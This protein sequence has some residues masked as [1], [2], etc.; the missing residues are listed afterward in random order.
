MGAES[1]RVTCLEKPEIRLLIPH[2][3]SMCLLDRVLYWDNDSILCSSETHRDRANPLRR[4][5]QLCAVHAF[6]YGAQSVALHGGLRARRAGQLAAPGY[7]AALRDARLQR[8]RLDDI[9]SALEIRARRLF[10]ESANA[11]YDCEVSADDRLVA[12]ARITILLRSSP[13]RDV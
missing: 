6:E 11:V 5:G 10:A 3:G 2:S 8:N 7:L 12:R 9:T 4:G 1:E 13:P